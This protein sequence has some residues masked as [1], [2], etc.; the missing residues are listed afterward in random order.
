MAEGRRPL[1]PSLEPLEIYFF[2]EKHVSCTGIKFLVIFRNQFGVA[3]TEISCRGPTSALRTERSGKN[4]KIPKNLKD[5]NF[6]QDQSN[7]VVG[8]KKV[9]LPKI[10]VVNELAGSGWESLKSHS[11]SSISEFKWS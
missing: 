3:L 1:E 5:I 6:I 10:T 7:N 4:L 2:M 9:K 8:Q 11:L